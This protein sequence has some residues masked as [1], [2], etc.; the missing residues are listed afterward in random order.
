MITPNNSHIHYVSILRLKS[1]GVV[2]ITVGECNEISLIVVADPEPYP[3]HTLIDF[4][5]I[6]SRGERERKGKYLKVKSEARG[7]AYRAV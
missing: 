2:T 1:A 3:E 7:W 5:A 4:R 6:K